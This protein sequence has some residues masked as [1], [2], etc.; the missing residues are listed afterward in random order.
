MWVTY[1][2]G[3]LSHA[4]SSGPTQGGSSAEPSPEVIAEFRSYLDEWYEHARA[5]DTFIWSEDVDPEQLE[6]LAHT[7]LRIVRRLAAQADDPGFSLPPP[8]SD[9]FYQ[10][11]V[12]GIIDALGQQ[13]NT[14]GEFSEQLRDRWPGLTEP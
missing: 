11:L 3:V 1:A 14:G 12:T 4:L 8:E 6:F 9:A 10:S 7:F 2:R 13:G 5:D